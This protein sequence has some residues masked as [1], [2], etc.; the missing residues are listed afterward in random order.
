MAN[1]V[2]LMID[3]KRRYALIKIGFTSNLPQRLQA[4]TTHNPEAECISTIRTQ[5]RSG[6]EVEHRYHEELKSKGYI[7]TIATIDGKRTEWH[8]IPYSDPFL[9]ELYAKGLTAFKCGKN[10]KDLGGVAK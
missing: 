1:T 9:Q 2:Y 5:E 4:Y 6:R 7:Q 8:R 10:R 3:E